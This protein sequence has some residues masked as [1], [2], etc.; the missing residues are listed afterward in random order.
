MSTQYLVRRKRF[1]PKGFYLSH[2]VYATCEEALQAIAGFVRQDAEAE[3]VDEPMVEWHRHHSPE[4]VCSDDDPNR[5]TCFAGDEDGIFASYLLYGL[6]GQEEDV[7][8]EF[9]LS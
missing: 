9:T 5:D 1:Y 8:K 2:F 7:E 3:Y 6:D 4:S